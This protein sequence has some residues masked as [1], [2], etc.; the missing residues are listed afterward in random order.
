[1][2]RF[3]IFIAGLVL[4]LFLQVNHGMAA[5]FSNMPNMMPSCGG[6]AK[7]TPGSQEKCVCCVL[8]QADRATS[9]SFFEKTNFLP[10]LPENSSGKHFTGPHHGKSQKK[11][12]KN[13]PHL[14]WLKGV[15][16]KK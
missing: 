7:N 10:S 12:S 4:V 2:K 3:G 5:G 14:A 16:Q 9:Q 13:C 11:S 8:S 6:E 1:M 15:V